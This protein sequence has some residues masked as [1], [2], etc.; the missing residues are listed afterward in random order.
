MDDQAPNVLIVD[1]ATSDPD[2]LQRAADWL[3]AGY[4]VA[5]PTDTLYGLA[6]DAWSPAAV[7]A[8]FGV[9]G[10]PEN[11]ALPLIAASMEQ[12]ERFAASLSPLSKRLAVEFWPGPLSLIVDAPASIVPAVHASLGTIAIRVPDHPVARALA[13]AFGRPITATSA[14]RSGAMPARV[15]EDLRDLAGDPR[16]LIVDAGPTPGGAPSTIVDARTAPPLLVRDGAIGWNRV[17]RS[18]EA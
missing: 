2:A 16:V 11:N 7:G 9:K 8:L 1:P 6:V 14:N 13:A 3:T 5:Y 10:R 15:P 17:L 4:I 12:A 18:L